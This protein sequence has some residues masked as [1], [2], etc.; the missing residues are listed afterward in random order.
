MDEEVSLLSIS[1]AFP[2]GIAQKKKM[3]KD[4]VIP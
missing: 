2:N 4:S 3:I 1:A